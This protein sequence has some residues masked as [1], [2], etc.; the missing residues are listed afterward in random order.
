MPAHLKTSGALVIAALLTA[1]STDRTKEP[2][3]SDFT[4]KCFVTLEDAIFLSRDCWQG[5][6]KYCDTVQPLTRF[7]GTPGY[8]E[9]A[10]QFRDAPGDWS[11]SI[12]EAEKRRQPPLER[13]HVAI[14]GAIP[15]GTPV[16]ILKVMDQFDGENGSF[17]V[18][19]ATVDA[20]EFK[21]RRIL[22]PTQRVTSKVIDYKYLARC[23]S[24]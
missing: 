7:T 6:G 9:S 4:N 24:H 19:T 16:T 15:A 3:L 17:Y 2:W 13:D 8:P 14:Y 23:D 10:Q 21:G 22:L 12:H 5:A 18:V 11:S 1:C 20:G